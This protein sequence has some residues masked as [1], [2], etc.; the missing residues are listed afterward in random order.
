MNSGFNFF[1]KI[2]HVLGLVIPVTLFFDPFQNA[3]GLV[4]ATRAILVS[5][6]GILLVSLLILEFV[7][8]NH[9]GFENFFYKYF[10]FLMKESERKRFNGTVPYF[11]ANFLVVL[12]F[13]AEVAI[14]AILFLVIGDPFAAYVGSKY[15]KHRFYNGKSL[16]GIIGFL[17]PA[18]LFSILALFLITKSQPGSF[19]AI[20][21]NQGAIF[22]T[23]IYLVFFSV[24]SA[25]VTEFFAN[26]TAKGL[27]DD[28]LLIPIVGAVVLSILSLLYLDYTPMDFFFDP[29]A[30]YIQ[31]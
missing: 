24:V 4:F 16:E 6:L 27:V 28:N 5:L 10:G 19:L 11:F 17:V 12:F 2:W 14:L 25:C 21:D 26:T 13:P 18:F 31:K 7:R 8:L 1:R 15:G 30:L 9:S 23:P 22:W 20:L 29:K 3:F